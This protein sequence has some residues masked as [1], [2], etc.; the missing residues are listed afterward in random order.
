[1]ATYHSQ[2]ISASSM[3]LY[4]QLDVFLYYWSFK[5][6]IAYDIHSSIYIICISRILQYCVLCWSPCKNAFTHAHILQ[7][8]LG[9]GILPVKLSFK[10]YS[11]ICL[12]AVTTHQQSPREIKCVDKYLC[13]QIQ[14][15]KWYVEFQNMLCEYL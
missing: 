10:E 13:L 7:E 8:S 3:T 9:L 15:H 6:A 2:I 4:M 1:M 14:Q 11:Y 12:C 5:L